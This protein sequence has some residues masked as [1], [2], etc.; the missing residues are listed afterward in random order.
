MQNEIEETTHHAELDA[1]R[2]LTAK[3]KERFGAD[4][5][6]SVAAPNLLEAFKDDDSQPFASPDLFANKMGIRWVIRNADVDLLDQCAT[7]LVS[8]TGASVLLAGIHVP[9]ATAAAAL[10]ATFLFLR[11]VS[12][13]GVKLNELQFAIVK[14]LKSRPK[15]TAAELAAFLEWSHHSDPHH[16]LPKYPSIEV[17]AAL[18]A[19]TA[20]PLNDGTVVPLVNQAA[21]GGWSTV[22]V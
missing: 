3:L 19:L 18:K 16:Q 6:E 1:A 11:K 12:R 20:V 9:V 5:A 15:M 17:D 8:T 2:A 21:D 4:F 22:G 10:V 13:K 14:G 7:G